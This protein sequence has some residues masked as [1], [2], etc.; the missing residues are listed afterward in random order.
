[1]SES[2]TTLLGPELATPRGASPYAEA[3]MSSTQERENTRRMMLFAGRS[4]PDLA[5]KIADELGMKLGRIRLKTFSDGEI[6]VRYDE[7]IRGADVFLVQ[8]GSAPVNRN[9]M[10][11]LIMVQGA[12]LAS[13]KRI[14]VVV[15]WYPYSRQDKKSSPREPITARLVADLLQVAGADRVLTMD[16]HAGQVQGFF[17]IPV[18]HMTALPQFAQYFRDKGLT[19]EKLV[20]VSADAGRAKLAKKFAEMLGADL[21]LLTKERPSHNTAEVTNIIGDVN[22]KVAII[23]DDIIDTAGTLCAGA[24]AI[25]KRG[26]TRVF[27]CATHPVFSGPALGRIEDSVLEQ[28]VVCDTIPV[29][30]VEAPGKVK[31]L[32]VARI[33]ADTIDNVF[34]D[35][36][37]SA[38]FEGENQL[39]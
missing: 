15:P 2:T 4:N 6:Y 29:D 37:V 31:V 22:G 36:S 34:R 11:L 1:M 39:F 32:S 24:E 33:L 16:L 28:V 30:P 9:L 20:V 19:R 18:D 26:A 5:K 7:S 27:A 21:A 3:E 10:E 17:D 38:I 25:S 12:K 23:S 8:S 35:D 13:A 14:T